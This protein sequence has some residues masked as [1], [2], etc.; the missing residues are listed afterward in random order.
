[1]LFRL[2][3]TEREIAQLNQW[4]STHASSLRMVHGTKAAWHDLQPVVNVDLYPLEILLH[5][6]EA[7][8][9]DQVRMTL[10]EVDKN[11]LL[12][13]AEAKNLTAAFSFFDALK[14]NQRLA[15]FTWEMAQPHSLANDVTQLQIEGTHASHE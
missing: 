14:K 13:K 1:M 15:G 11:H 7:L 3:S 6:S 12:I 4:Q 2:F 10:F 8:P 5:V 9:A